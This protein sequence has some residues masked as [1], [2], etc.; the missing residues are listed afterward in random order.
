MGDIRDHGGKGSG[1][2]YRPLLTKRFTPTNLEGHRAD[3]SMLF[4]MNRIDKLCFP[5]KT[6]IKEVGDDGKHTFCG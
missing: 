5:I 2:R 6:M 1:H 4:D 3:I